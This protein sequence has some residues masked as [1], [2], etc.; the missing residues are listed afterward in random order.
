MPVFSHDDGLRREMVGEMPGGGT[1]LEGMGKWDCG[2]CVGTM[3]SSGAGRKRW[4]GREGNA[5]L[6]PVSPSGEGNGG[7]QLFFYK[8]STVRIIGYDELTAFNRLD[9]HFYPSPQSK[10]HGRWHPS[11]L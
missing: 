4:D 3:Q 8:C 9:I 1:R 10:S 5:V 6:C 11:P 2:L 7:R